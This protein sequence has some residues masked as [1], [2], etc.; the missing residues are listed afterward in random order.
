M[1]RRGWGCSEAKGL[2]EQVC[3]EKLFLNVR[4]IQ[5]SPDE[6]VVSGSKVDAHLTRGLMNRVQGLPDD[7]AVGGEGLHHQH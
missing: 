6:P 3:F 7:Q 2:G 4:V 5:H 1:G